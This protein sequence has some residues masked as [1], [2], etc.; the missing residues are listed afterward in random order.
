MQVSWVRIRCTFE[1]WNGFPWN[2]IPSLFRQETIALTPGARHPLRLDPK[3]IRSHS[4]RPRV[5]HAHVLRVLSA[6]ALIE[7]AA[8]E[9]PWHNAEGTVPISIQSA[10][11]RRDWGSL[12]HRT[13]NARDTQPDKKQRCFTSALVSFEHRS[14]INFTS[15]IKTHAQILLSPAYDRDIGPSRHRERRSHP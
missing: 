9:R 15:T 3:T 12:G 6:L 1:K 14:R 7:R 11:R 8:D 4:N 13:I 5:R 2:V 10:R